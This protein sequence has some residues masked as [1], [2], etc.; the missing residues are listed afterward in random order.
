MLQLGQGLQNAQWI[1][2]EFL[3]LVFIVLGIHYVLIV[4]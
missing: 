1:V 4:L 3:K 2:P